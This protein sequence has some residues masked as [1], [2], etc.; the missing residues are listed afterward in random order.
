MTIEQLRNVHWAS[1]FVPFTIRVADGRSFL[2]R[3]P[4]FLSHSPTGRTMIV[5]HDDDTFSIL[6]LLLVTELEVHGGARG[7]GEAAA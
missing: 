2:V 6:D 7:A 4:E 1:P 5:H 3:H